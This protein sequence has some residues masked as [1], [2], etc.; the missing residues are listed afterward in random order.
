MSETFINPR[1]TLDEI[2]VQTVEAIV[3]RIIAARSESVCA[4]QGPMTMTVDELAETLGI[5][6]IKAYEL[7]NTPEFPSF[8]V[9]KRILVSRKG[10]Q[11][12]IKKQCNEQTKGQDYFI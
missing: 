5:A 8:K 4:E 3:D 6:K 12:W 9:G 11:E 1:I 10:L 7:T 2:I